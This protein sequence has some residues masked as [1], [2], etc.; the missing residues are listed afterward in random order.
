M[1]SSSRRNIWCRA[2]FAKTVLARYAVPAVDRRG[3]VLP[4]GPLF[5]IPFDDIACQVFGD[6]ADA[7]RA[8]LSVPEGDDTEDESE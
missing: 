2:F 3:I 8:A 7:K 6:E 4:E 1:T 5:I